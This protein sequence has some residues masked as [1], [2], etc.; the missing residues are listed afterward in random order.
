[1]KK[2]DELGLVGIPNTK[3]LGFINSVLM[4]LYYNWAFKQQ[5]SLFPQEEVP[6]EEKKFVKTL[7]K[8]FRDLTYKKKI[9]TKLIQETIDELLPDFGHFS[10]DMCQ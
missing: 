4:H 7:A 6:S 10:T 1:M 5:L 3:G 8:T 9:D 2:K